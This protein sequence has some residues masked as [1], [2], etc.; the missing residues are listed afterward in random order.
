[1]TAPKLFADE[2][3]ILARYV[4]TI[5]GISLDD[6]KKYLIETRLAPLLKDLG[7]VSFSEL[8][9]KATSDASKKIQEKIIDAI[10]T[11][12]T[13][14]FRDA[15]PFELLQHKIIPDLVDTRSK[16]VPKTAPVP[17][18]IWSAAC[19]TGQEIYSIAMV[20]KELFGDLS[21]YS[22]RLIGTDISDAAVARAS[23]GTFNNFEIDRGL[24]KDRLQKYFVQSNGS[25]KVRDEVRAMVSFKK[26]NLM[27]NFNGI[28]KFDIIFCRNVAIYFSEADRAKLF[29]KIE[30]A[31]EPDGYLVIGSTESLT[32]IAPQFEPK[33]YLRSVFYQT[34]NV[35]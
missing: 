3:K 11:G 17:L 27:E 10:T 23:Y 18:R 1:L 8:Y 13:L 21:R 6:S 33:R 31:L 16:R 12:E 9:Y 4:L 7:L 22:I 20:L 30:G 24:A 35:Q 29:K 2:F 32:G 5:S 25:W 26:L 28:G 14:F 19:S 34:R 15:A